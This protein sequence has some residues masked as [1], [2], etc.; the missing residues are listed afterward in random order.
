MKLLLYYKAN[1]LNHQKKAIE[2]AKI[3]IWYKDERLRIEKKYNKRYDDK[4]I[5]LRPQYLPANTQDQWQAWLDA[6]D[7]LD[8][9]NKREKNQELKK[10]KQQYEEKLNKQKF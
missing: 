8:S 4:V 1:V 7:S 3:I 5:E 9:N 6:C 2:K 10:L